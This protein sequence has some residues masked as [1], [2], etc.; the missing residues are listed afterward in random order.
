MSVMVRM[1]A[2]LAEVPPENVQTARDAMIPRLP[3]PHGNPP[4]GLD[5]AA[6]SRKDHARLTWVDCSNVA[7]IR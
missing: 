6:V 5:R 4:Q 3:G 1:V 2:A 7:N